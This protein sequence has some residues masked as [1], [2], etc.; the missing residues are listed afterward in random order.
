MNCDVCADVFVRVIKF[1]FV[2]RSGRV[3]SL[4][5]LGLL[6]GARGLVDLKYV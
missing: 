2:W 4:R 5:T 1:S 6:L 3:L